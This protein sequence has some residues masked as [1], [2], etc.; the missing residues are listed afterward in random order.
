M[1]YTDKDEIEIEILKASVRI[2]ELIRQRK[3][4]DCKLDGERQ[5]IA[6]LK[7]KLEEVEKCQK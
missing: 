7:D 1:A 4:I 3:L 5:F 6:E 2:E